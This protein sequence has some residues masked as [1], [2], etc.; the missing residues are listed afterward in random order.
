MT[1]EERH[2]KTCVKI[3]GKKEISNYSQKGVGV[4]GVVR[5]KERKKG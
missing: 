3:K 2:R 5:K 1:Q 4:E